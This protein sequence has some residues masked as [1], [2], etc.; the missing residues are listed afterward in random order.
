MFLVREY[1][2]N[3]LRGYTLLQQPTHSIEV[4]HRR[5]WFYNKQNKFSIYVYVYKNDIWGLL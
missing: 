3:L 2:H 1:I 5:T 4:A